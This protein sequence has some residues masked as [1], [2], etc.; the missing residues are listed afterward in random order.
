MHI[1]DKDIRDKNNDGMDCWEFTYQ[2]IESTT[3][4]HYEFDMI[5]TVDEKARKKLKEGG[6]G[7]F[8][9]KIYYNKKRLKSL[10]PN[11]D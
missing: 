1:E 11:T 10:H 7:D 8:K 2:Q 5:N 6:K 3:M 9:K 4:S